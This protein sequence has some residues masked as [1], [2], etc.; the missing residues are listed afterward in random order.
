MLN[1]D[2][3]KIDRS[4]VQRDLPGQRAQIVL[5]N[6]IRLALELEMAVICEGVETAEQAAILMRLGC[7]KAQGF[8]YATPEPENEFEA[9]LAMQIS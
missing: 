2:V 6:I 3:I 5:G 9:R 1:A 8:Y 7:F 4:F